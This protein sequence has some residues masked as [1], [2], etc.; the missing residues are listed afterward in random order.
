MA[1]ESAR[2]S[3]AAEARFRVQTPN[4]RPRATKVIALDAAADAVVRRLAS[5]GREHAAFFTTG[6]D[7]GSVVIQDLSGHAHDLAEGVD[8]ADLVV[9]LAG[10]GGHADAASFIG[11]ACS[12]RSI[13]T[14]ALVVGADSASDRELSKTLAQLRPWSLMVVLAKGD[15]Y[16]DDMLTA[17]R[18]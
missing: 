1:S 9:M 8:D 3:S 12:R 4:S 15:Q 18:A 2:M 10:S 11:E 16:I 6:L 17:L 5:A 7:H 14:T 13:M